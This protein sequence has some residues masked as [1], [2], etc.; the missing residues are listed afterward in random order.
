MDKQSE[1]A[2]VNIQKKAL[3]I[4]KLLL[5]RLNGFIINNLN[6]KNKIQ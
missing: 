5:K 4:Y 1:N 2:N 3:D 6:G